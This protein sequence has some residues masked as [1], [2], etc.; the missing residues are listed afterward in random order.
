MQFLKN[1]IYYRKAIVYTLYAL[2]TPLN[3]DSLLLLLRQ[4]SDK[5][6]EYTILTSG[7]IA[8]FNT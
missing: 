5:K 4:V 7:I 3:N 8:F 1:I 6:Y 2:Q